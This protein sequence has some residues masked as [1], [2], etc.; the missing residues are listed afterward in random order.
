VEALLSNGLQVA[1]RPLPLVI[2]H[3]W[4]AATF[5]LRPHGTQVRASRVGGEEEEGGGG[6]GGGRHE[7][8]CTGTGG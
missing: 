1:I 3:R 7:T 8:R 4:P 6:G 2:P 5:C